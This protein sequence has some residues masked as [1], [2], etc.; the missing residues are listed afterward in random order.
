VVDHK[1]CRIK[2]FSVSAWRCR[3][4]RLCGRAVASCST[5]LQL[6]RWRRALQTSS[7]FSELESPTLWPNAEQFH[8]TLHYIE[9]FNVA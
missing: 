4:C 5:T 1:M 8:I 2:K 9:I 7:E 3:C 6:R